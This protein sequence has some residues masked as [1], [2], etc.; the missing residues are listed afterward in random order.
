M[1]IPDYRSDNIVGNMNN[2]MN[3]NNNYAPQPNYGYQNNVMT[4]N[5]PKNM[6]ISINYPTSSL[7]HP[8]AITIDPKTNDFNWKPSVTPS[9]QN[10]V[11]SIVPQVSSV[12]ARTIAGSWVKLHRLRQLPAGPVKREDQRQKSRKKR[13]LLAQARYENN[14]LYTALKARQ[15]SRRS[16]YAKS[17]PM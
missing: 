3:N 12:L 15:V 16:H 13:A 5:E 1:M 6:T 7:Q 9:K 2:M 17:D 4:E 14:T 11:P 10:N 8:V